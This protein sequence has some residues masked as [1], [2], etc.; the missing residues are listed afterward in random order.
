ME[1]LFLLQRQTLD[2]GVQ[3]DKFSPE[4]PNYDESVSELDTG[5]LTMVVL[6]EW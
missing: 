4:R 1:N 2:V 3:Q 6:I 5:I